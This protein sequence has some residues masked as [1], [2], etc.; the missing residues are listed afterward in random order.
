[1]SKAMQF[2]KN[3]VAVSYGDGEVMSRTQ[4]LEE[5]VQVRFSVD[6]GGF[7][8]PTVAGATVVIVNAG[9]HPAMAMPHRRSVRLY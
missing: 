2:K 9:E 4:C 3:T 7:T 8:A 6:A 1:M 5:M